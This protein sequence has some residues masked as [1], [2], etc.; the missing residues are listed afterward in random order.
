ME[1][2]TLINLIVKDSSIEK[3]AC[4]Y[5]GV[6]LEAVIGAFIDEKSITEAV[7]RGKDL[8]L[9]PV[10]KPLK[11]YY[12]CIAKRLKRETPMTEEERNMLWPSKTPKQDAPAPQ[13]GGWRSM[14]PLLEEQ[15]LLRRLYL[16][17]VSEWD[18]IDDF[19]T[20]VVKRST[21]TQ[22]H[23]AYTVSGF[24]DAL[25]KRLD[26]ITL[27]KNNDT[28]YFLSAVKREILALISDIDLLW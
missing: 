21:L 24:A 14:L 16:D 4:N 20:P 9:M 23:V 11:D 27:P 12:N 18:G 8:I 3:L 26:K 6:V 1:K 2:K 22:L 28:K 25:A 5:T 7:S 15:S 13:T 17:S 19:L 10:D